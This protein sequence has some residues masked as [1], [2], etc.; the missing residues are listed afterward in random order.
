MVI[1][2]GEI[3]W[4]QLNSNPIGSSPGFR[5]PVLIIQ[6]NAINQSNLNTVI[7]VAITSN[8]ALTS[9]PL[10][11]QLEPLESGLPQVSVVNV[12]QVQTIDKSQLEQRV[13][14]LPSGTFQKII[15]NLRHVLE[16]Q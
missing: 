3:W 11:V 10:N 5:R 13:Q 7:I 4:A 9:I 15:Q 16:M 12:S 14:K 6:A 1:E 8:L 2:R